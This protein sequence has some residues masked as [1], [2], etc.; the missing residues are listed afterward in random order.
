MNKLP[1]TSKNNN[2]ATMGRNTETCVAKYGALKAILHCIH[3]K[4]DILEYTE[5]RHRD[6]NEKDGEK[7]DRAVAGH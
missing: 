4:Q 7:E 3:D 6:R 5:Q 2:A 1:S